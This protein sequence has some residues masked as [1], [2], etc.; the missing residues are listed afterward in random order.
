MTS[1]Y[2]DA[3]LG[4][5]LGKAIGGTLGQPFEG[6][7][8]P[9]S[10][11]FYDPVP[12]EM[13]PNDDLDLQVVWACVLSEQP[14]PSVTSGALAQAWTTHVEF[15]FNEYGIAK[16][17]LREGIAPP[18]SGSFDN[19]FT[20]G[21]GAA[22][23]SE[24]WAC[25]APGD[26]EAAAE[27]AYRDACVD[28]AGD[29]VFAPMF[30]A[31][32]QSQAFLGGSIDALLDAGLSVIPAES[33]IAQVVT[34]TRSWFKENQD[35]QHVR[36]QIL[37]RFESPDFTDVR[38][39][40]GFV[41]LG[42]LAGDGDFVRCI[43]ITSNCGKDT[44]S[45][46]ASVGATIGILSP[47]SI[48]EEW[49]APIGNQLVVSP[50]IVGLAAPATI[51]AFTDLVLELRDRLRF[52]EREEAPAWDAAQKTVE[53]QQSWSTR[54]GELGALNDWFMPPS[55]GAEPMPLGPSTATA[56]E[57]TWARMA[58]EDFEDDLLVL[59]YRVNTNDVGRVRVMV[60]SNLM[61][62]V[63]FDGSWLFGRDEGRVFP[64]PHMP[65][66]NTYED[67]DV[68]AP[69]HD[70]TVVLHR[71]EAGTVGEWIVGIAD[72]DTKEW[73]PNALR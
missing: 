21:E 34:A 50:G 4:C 72:A 20:C 43:L 36:S 8:G 19:W 53:V 46:A 67:L 10:A 52:V 48:P 61:V 1:T 12:T 40:T 25:L 9:L 3:V 11:T 27:Y 45:S 63:W 33:G 42:L 13:V 35:W 16:R 49:L 31:A 41:V 56:L 24:L 55:H 29:G 69:L 2:R 22:I 60:A 64:S 32:M 62:R 73:I 51:D 6:L 18:H 68:S 28:H 57:G 15:P 39:N 66:I 5:W 17:N 58:A 71:P 44:D 37:D 70:L 47:G 54:A 38:M 7:D 23:R 14:A 26:P 59:R 65:H 30:L